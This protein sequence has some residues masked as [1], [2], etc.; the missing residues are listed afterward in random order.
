MDLREI[1]NAIRCMARRAGGWRMLPTNLGSPHDLF[2]TDAVDGSC[3]ASCAKL[4]A[5]S[6]TS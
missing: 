5:V 4:V 2:K 1:L 3:S 6:A